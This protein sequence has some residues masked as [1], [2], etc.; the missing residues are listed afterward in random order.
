MNIVKP[1]VAASLALGLAACAG[2][3]GGAGEQASTD[4][5][6]NPMDLYS[7]LDTDQDGNI[8][9][10]EAAD[11]EQLTEDFDDLDQDRD[12]VL[13]ADEFVEWESFEESSY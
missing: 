11:N 3:Y 9:N 13:S 7:Q 4:A 5:Q 6:Q 2:T 10:Y 12:G 1:L 8:S